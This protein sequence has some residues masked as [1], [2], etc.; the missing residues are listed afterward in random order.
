MERIHR[1]SLFSARFVFV[2]LITVVACG[3]DHSKA[4]FSLNR[5]EAKSHVAKERLSPRKDGNGVKRTS[6]ALGFQDNNAIP[7]QP[8]ANVQKPNHQNGWK[9]FLGRI[10][11]FF[12]GT[13]WFLPQTDP[14][15]F[16]TEE[17]APKS[18][19]MALRKCLDQEPGLVKHIVD[20]AVLPSLVYNELYKMVDKVHRILKQ[21]GIYYNISCGTA[22]GFMRHKGIIPWDTD[23]DIGLMRADYERLL[24]DENFQKDLSA[25]GLKLCPLKEQPHVFRI[26]MKK[27]KGP[28]ACIDVF[29]YEE[30]EDGRITYVDSYCFA[31]WGGREYFLPEEIKSYEEKPFGPTKVW[32]PNGIKN[33]IDRAYPGWDKEFLMHRFHHKPRALVRRFEG[34]PIPIRPGLCKPGPWSPKDWPN[35]PPPK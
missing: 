14:E 21:R 22:I 8:S 4:V 1:K 24:A 11:Q 33:H 12:F 2:F 13:S 29:A 26:R 6:E 31:R 19:R 20:A 15:E 32:V 17:L 23:I 18:V 16:R 30:K 35:V 3:F 5:L 25:E 7:K 28:R 27:R 34:V 10:C 9:G